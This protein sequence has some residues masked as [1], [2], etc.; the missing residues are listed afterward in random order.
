MQ[1]WKVPAEGGPTVQVTKQGG[2]EGFESADGKYFYYAKGR[3]VPGIWRV[4]VAGGEESLV[5]DQHQ[6][7]LWRYWALTAKGILL[8]VVQFLLNPLPSLN[9]LKLKGILLLT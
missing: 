3:A 9:A 1:I 2:F 4:P 8:A 5:R 7:G 6:A